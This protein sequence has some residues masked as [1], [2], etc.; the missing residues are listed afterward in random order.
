MAIM[1]WEKDE[2]VAILTM[3]N[4]A[5]KQN[6]DFANTM[7]AMLDE[8]IADKAVTALIITSNDEKNFSQG[9]DVEWIL[10][11]AQKKEYQPVIDFIRGMDVVFK[12]LVAYPVPV[13]AAIN[14]HAFGNGSIMS[15]A[16]D[17]RFMRSDKGFFCFPEVNLGIPFRAGMNAFIKKAVPMYKLVE[18]QLTGNRYTAKE[19]EAHHVILKACEDQA[20]LMAQALAFAKTF[21]K[22]RGIFGE[23]KK[24][25]NKEIIEILEAPDELASGGSFSLTI[26]N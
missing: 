15:C 13:I 19:M 18:M 12:K 26:D 11:K 2:T 9:I 8:I 7:N 22:K 16:C 23:L 25:L 20:D 14:G 4:G 6:L 17:F 10:D 1:K 21:K 5:N 24:R 3:T